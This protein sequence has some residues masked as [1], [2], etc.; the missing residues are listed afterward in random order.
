MTAQMIVC[1]IVPVP[2]VVLL[3]MMN[4][5]EYA[6]QISVWVVVMM[7]E[8]VVKILIVPVFVAVIV[9]PVGVVVVTDVL[10]KVLR[11]G[12][13]VAAGMADISCYYEVSFILLTAQ[14]TVLGNI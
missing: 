12:V 8:S 11:V 13:M 9:L 10:V 5:V 4:V 7:V 14:L 1:R 2:G 6:N 3:Y